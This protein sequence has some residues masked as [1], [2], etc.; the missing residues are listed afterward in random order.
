MNHILLATSLILSSAVFATAPTRFPTLGSKDA[1]V[2]IIGFIDYQCP[3][4]KAAS[5]TMDQLLAQNEGRIQIVYL[6][7]PLSFHAD[8]K[9]AAIAAFCAHDQDKFKGMHDYLFANQQNLRRSLY[10][11]FALDNGY[12]MDAFEACLEAPET[13]ATIQFDLDDAAAMRANATP[14]FFFASDSEIRKVVG[15]ANLGDYQKVVDELSK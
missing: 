13:A 11:G 12:N 7:L 3:F 1:P 14:T 5:G 10:I 4:A 2:T 8:A 6:N 9:P 15:A